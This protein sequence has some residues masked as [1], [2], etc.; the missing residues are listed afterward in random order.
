MLRSIIF[1]LKRRARHL[2]PR[3]PLGDPQEPIPRIRWYR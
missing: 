1:T 2:L 3:S